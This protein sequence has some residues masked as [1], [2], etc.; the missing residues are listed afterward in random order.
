[1]A[2][3]SVWSDNRFWQRSA[4]WVTGFAS[5]LLIWLTLDTSA[6]ISMGND[7]DL[8][9][10]VQKRVPGPTAVSYTHLTLPTKA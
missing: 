6:Q 1:M 5:I 8:K 4:T 2:N 7:E 10:G 3:K 9:N